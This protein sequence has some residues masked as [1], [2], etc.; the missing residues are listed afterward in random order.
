M[1]A[2]ALFGAFEN[3]EIRWNGDLEDPQWIT[4]DVARVLEIGNYRQVVSRYPD[5]YK[6]VTTSDGLDGKLREMLTLT[7]PGLYRMIFASRKPEAEKFRAWVFEEVLPSIRKTGS[8]LRIALRIWCGWWGIW[9][10]GRMRIGRRFVRCNRRSGGCKW[11]IGGF[12]MC[13]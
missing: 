1:N 5:N 11:R 8:Y 2:I 6:G 7:E 4:Q 3:Q 12:W 9:L 10:R 13:C